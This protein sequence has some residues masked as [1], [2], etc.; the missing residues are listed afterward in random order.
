MMLAVSVNVV[1]IEQTAQG[2]SSHNRVTTAALLLV[3][4]QQHGYV[5][6]TALLWQEKA[7]GEPQQ[8]NNTASTS[9]GHL[10]NTTQFIAKERNVQNIFKAF[11]FDLL[12]LQESTGVHLGGLGGG[13]LGLRG[14]ISH[15]PTFFWATP[16]H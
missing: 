3:A 1:G 14:N 13:A 6:F 2:I 7:H 10:L 8:C 9:P 5:S 16:T 4:H 12:F 11:V 15:I